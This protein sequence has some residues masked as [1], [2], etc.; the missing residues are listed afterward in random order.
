[1]KRPVGLPGERGRPIGGVIVTVV[2]SRAPPTRL[3]RLP[4]VNAK[5]DSA[6]SCLGEA[7]QWQLGAL[8]MSWF[9]QRRCWP[10]QA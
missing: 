4:D 8:G 10:R 9:V 6:R 2:R 3:A 1:M 7:E 5:P